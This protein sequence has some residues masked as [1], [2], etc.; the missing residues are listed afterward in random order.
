[1]R[2]LGAYRAAIVLLAGATT[3]S[4]QTG[5]PA[6]CDLDLNNQ[7]DRA[8]VQMIFAARG[9]IV[10]GG[11]GSAGDPRDQDG[12]G[13]IT[14][15]DARQCVNDCDFTNCLA[16]PPP[17]TFGP[18]EPETD[19]PAR[20]SGPVTVDPDTCL[21]SIQWNPDA[22]TA[23]EILEARET[24]GTVC[25]EPPNYCDQDLQP[26]ADP[27]QAAIAGCA[28]FETDFCPP[29]L[30]DNQQ[31]WCGDNLGDLAGDGAA[32]DPNCETFIVCPEDGDVQTGEADVPQFPALPPP[33]PPP[34]PPPFPGG[35][36]LGVD[37]TRAIWPCVW[38]A[39]Q[40]QADTNPIEIVPVD[41][42][43][44]V[45]RATNETCLDDH[46]CLS[47]RCD[48]SLNR[49][50]L[51]EAAAD[52]PYRF[53]VFKGNDSWAIEVEG[54]LSAGDVRAQGLFYPSLAYQ[55]NVAADLS[56]VATI[57]GSQSEIL[58][59]EVHAFLDYC[60]HHWRYELRLFG[61]NEDYNSWRLQAGGAYV[62][63]DN[64]GTE[65]SALDV[66]GPEVSQCRDALMTLRRQEE[67]T[68]QRLWNALI[69][70]FMNRT[71]DI[72]TFDDPAAVTPLIGEYNLSVD[73]YVSALQHF[74][75]KQPAV[76]NHAEFLAV[77]DLSIGFAWAV[78]QSANANH[79]GPFV[80]GVE[81]DAVGELGL[82]VD[83]KSKT[84]W[85]VPEN[86]QELGGREV[87]AG[88]E[89]DPFFA[90]GVYAAIYGGID[91]GLAS[92]KA[93]VSG[94]VNLLGAHLPVVADIALDR[95]L[96]VI[97]AGTLDGCIPLEELN[98]LFDN[99]PDCFE[100]PGGL[101]HVNDITPDGARWLIPWG[102]NIAGTGR[103]LD[104]IIE[105]FLRAEALGVYKGQWEKTLA[106]W[107]GAEVTIFEIDSLYSACP[108]DAFDGAACG[109]ISGDACCR[110]DGN[111][112]VCDGDLD[113]LFVADPLQGAPEGFGCGGSIF[114]AAQVTVGEQNLPLFGTVD[115][116]LGRQRNFVYLPILNN[117]LADDSGALSFAD[118][119]FN[120]IESV[121]AQNDKSLW[122]RR[123]D[124]P[125]FCPVNTE[126]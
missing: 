21:P 16:L 37:G 75:A 120:Y 24:D 47:D 34:P 58:F 8:D 29:V 94:Q 74:E 90:V 50:L 6:Q 66:L 79:M 102:W 27:E 1:V 7:V 59:N 125:S 45:G 41:S 121:V 22:Q 123:F 78:Y 119:F 97:D 46:D 17:P 38:D 88:V 104:G 115:V 81:V 9:T 2:E 101:Q 63:I 35:I 68:N 118:D 39:F 92:V 40:D 72:G 96:E 109:T 107:E 30:F 84:Q 122:W 25:L 108:N 31:P 71:Y 73:E 112:L 82:Q 93:G 124:V 126:G 65:Q 13:V 18:F 77:A 60:S 103:F 57:K 56:V 76:T 19:W 52:N 70:I 61:V 55:A 114:D 12:D 89:A 14:L 49:C 48:Q 95:Q 62:D 98:I 15:K 42:Y 5:G 105:L 67:I 99:G 26:I 51:P 106:K 87:Q 10:V 111:A 85:G 116:I 80:V 36:E 3:V 43:N 33:Q 20:L 44:F 53:D 69:A 11:P 4:A 54:G 110:D 23:A 91:L 117:N 83:M 28:A 100:I 113:Q 86:D 32:F 64:I